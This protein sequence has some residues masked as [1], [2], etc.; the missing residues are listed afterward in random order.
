MI[1]FSMV[2]CH[3]GPA[4]TDYTEGCAR[5]LEGTVEIEGR[6]WRTSLFSALEDYDVWFTALRREQSR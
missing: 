3:G 2:A 6:A 5:E 1:H 4:W